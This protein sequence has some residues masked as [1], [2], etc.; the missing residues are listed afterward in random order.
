LFKSVKIDVQRAY[1]NYKNAIESY[2]ASLAQY[3][4]GELAIRTQR[5][6][7]ELGVSSQIEL[8]Q[9]NQTFTQALASRA[10]AEVTLVFQQV[11]LE[12]ALGTL[13]FEETP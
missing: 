13:Y 12:Y 7:Y 4:A 8:A 9:A 2:Q 1:N 6:S 11:L 10:Q 5:E 3:E